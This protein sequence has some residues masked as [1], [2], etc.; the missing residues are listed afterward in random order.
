MS[1]AV[2]QPH[3]SKQDISCLVQMLLIFM[4]NVVLLNDGLVASDGLSD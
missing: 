3:L 1:A 4:W 2:T